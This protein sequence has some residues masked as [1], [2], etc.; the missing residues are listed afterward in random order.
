MAHIM[1]CLD[2]LLGLGNNR[3]MCQVHIEIHNPQTQI[4]KE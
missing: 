4:I 3:D 1:G 2:L